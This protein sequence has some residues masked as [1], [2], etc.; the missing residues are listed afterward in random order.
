VAYEVTV[1][2]EPELLVASTTRYVSEATVGTEVSEGFGTLMKAVGPIGYG[3]GMPGVVYFD[4]IDEW[5]DGTIEIFMPLARPF[6]PPEGVE[7][8]TFPSMT[9]AATIH[10]GPY[11][12]C[13]LAYQA[14]VGWIREHGHEIAGPPRELYLND[15][16]EVGEDEALTE[17]QF[18]IR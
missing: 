3:Q 13:A 4:T 9:V 17:I 5:T 11:A 15:P 12:E 6:E 10:R 14:L 1:K 18:P 7:V 16:R 2:E 8:K